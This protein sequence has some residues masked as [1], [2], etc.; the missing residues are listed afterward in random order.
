MPFWYAILVDWHHFVDSCW[1]LS[2]LSPINQLVN[3]WWQLI[4]IHSHITPSFSPHPASEERRGWSESV[5]ATIAKQR[6]RRWWGNR[7]RPGASLAIPQYANRLAK[8][9]QQIGDLAKIDDNKIGSIARS[10][11]WFLVNE[12]TSWKKKLGSEQN[13]QIFPAWF[14]MSCDFCIP[15][16]YL[17]NLSTQTRFWDVFSTASNMLALPS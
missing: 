16:R 13:L 8:N 9:Y 11:C 14:A 15:A 4:L 7:E 5:M 17:A 12:Y 1:L 6:Q 10:F 2:P 3:R